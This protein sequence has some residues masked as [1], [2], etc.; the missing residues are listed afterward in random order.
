[1]ENLACAEFYKHYVSIRQCSFQFSLS[2][3][4]ESEN[5]CLLTCGLFVHCTESREK[6]EIWSMKTI[7]Y[8]SF[9]SNECEHGFFLF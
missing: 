5:D 9:I 1:M 7:D 3:A 4:T 8:K 2:D 6:V